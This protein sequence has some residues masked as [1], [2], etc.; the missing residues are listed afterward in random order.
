MRDIL[1]HRYGL[2]GP[3]VDWTKVW[4]VMAGKFE[5]ELLKQLDEAVVKE[6]NSADE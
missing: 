4:A 1:T 5:S 3:E 6:Q 2:P